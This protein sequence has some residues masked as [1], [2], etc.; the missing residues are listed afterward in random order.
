MNTDGMA[1]LLAELLEPQIESGRYGTIGR[2]RLRE[3]LTI[4]PNL[5]DTE[6]SILL[7]SPVAREDYQDVQNEILNE[8]NERIHNQGVDIKILPLAA[9]SEGK[10][11]KII[12]NGRGFTVTLYRK[13]DLGIPWVILV[14]LGASYLKVIN[15]MTTLRLVDSGG[16]EWL[17]GIPDTN[18]EMTGP[19][20]DEE[21]DLLRR[22][23][24][25][26]LTLEPV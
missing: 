8:V 2:D 15:P 14:Q 20:N 3:A 4:G 23:Q 16:L 21:T 18:G 9:A 24:R 13:E 22:V 7:I 11:D 10:K 5:T 6:Q 19:W 17:R 12:L 26:S 25:F 1:R